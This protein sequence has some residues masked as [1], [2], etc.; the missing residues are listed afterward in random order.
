MSKVNL[1]NATQRGAVAACERNLRRLKTD[2]LDVYLL[3]WRGSVP[4]AETVEGFRT[5]KQAGKIL[6]YGV[7]NFD[8]DA[9]EAF[10]LR[11]GA[12]VVTDQLFYN[13]MRRGIE[14]DLLP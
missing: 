10:A 2:H 6:H 1:H 12:E 13:L 11:G 14:W 4:L 5:L 8:Q 3:D 9:M 7:S